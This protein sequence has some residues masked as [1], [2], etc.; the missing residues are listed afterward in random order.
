MDDLLPSGSTIPP[1]LQPF[2][3]P[4]FNSYLQVHSVCYQ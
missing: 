1:E 4:F 3:M 2:G